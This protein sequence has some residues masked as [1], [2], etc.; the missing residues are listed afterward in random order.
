MYFTE[1][2]ESEGVQ[3]TNFKNFKMEPGFQLPF[4]AN[5]IFVVGIIKIYLS[6]AIKR[7]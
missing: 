4:G 1:C 7:P 5:L 2:D 3:I 6:S